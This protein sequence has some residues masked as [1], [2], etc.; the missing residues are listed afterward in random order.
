MRRTL[1]AI[2]ALL[3][4]APAVAADLRP[5]Y[6]APAMAA[7]VPMVNWTGFYVGGNIGGGWADVSNSTTF[8]GVT[9]S[10]SE[11]L[12]GV[13]GGGQIGYN[14]QFNNWLIGVEADLQGSG[15]RRDYS[16][17]IGGLA[18]TGTDRIPWFGTVRGRIG[19]V[20]NSWLVYFT[21][22]GAWGE[23]ES[24]ATATFGGV[25]VTG[26]TSDTHAAWTIGGGLETMLWDRWSG[27][28]EYL[29]IDTGDISTSFGAATMTTRV[30]DNILR[31]GL[32][33]HF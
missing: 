13:I 24:T 6:K 22:G 20:W 15:Q 14:W 7:P 2:S 17:A 27:K 12:S 3:I 21:G 25:T 26:S 23:F 5:A 30:R 19:A 10:G 9:F 28:I 11:T 31:V 8:G 16:G 4:A 33:Y 32:N 1:L 29:Y 18:V